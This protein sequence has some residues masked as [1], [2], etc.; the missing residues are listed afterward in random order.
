MV[1]VNVRALALH[2][3]EIAIQAKAKRTPARGP[4]QHRCL[5]FIG[6]LLPSHDEAILVT[7]SWC[8]KWSRF[9]PPHDHATGGHSRS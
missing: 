7:N 6:N 1:S 5:D 8:L 4:E 9:E 3:S 2:T